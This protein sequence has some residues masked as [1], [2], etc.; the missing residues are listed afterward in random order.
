MAV[1][2]SNMRR[3]SPAFINSVSRTTLF[4]DGIAT[5]SFSSLRTAMLV[6]PIPVEM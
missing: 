2:N 6:P 1:F 3:T 5:A 4:S